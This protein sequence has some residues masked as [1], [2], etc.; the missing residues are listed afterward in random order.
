MLRLRFS[1]LAIWLASATSSCS[2][3]AVCGDGLLGGSEACDDGN[4][5]TGDGCSAECRLETGWVCTGSAP[6]VC[7]GLRGDGLV[8]GSEVCDDGNIRDGDG[9][10][11]R[12]E[13]EP[14]WQCEGSFCDGICG[15]GERRGTETCDDGNEQA[16]DG[17]SAGCRIED[18][19]DCR[20]SS[21]YPICGDGELRGEESCDDGERSDGDGCSAS[22]QIEDGWAC[23]PEAPSFCY[24][25]CGDG[26]LRGEEE[27]DDGNTMRG[28]GCRGTCRIEDGWICE[29]GEPTVCEEDCGD[30]QM[31]G[32]EACDDGDT[33]PDDA[34]SGACEPLEFAVNQTAADSQSWPS[35][36]MAPDGRF[37]IAWQ[38]FAQDGDGF[39]IYMRL[40]DAGGLP[41]SAELAVNS[42]T[43]EGQTYP[44]ASMADDGRLVVVWQSWEQ[45]GSADGVFGQRFAADGRKQGGEF[46]IPTAVAGGQAWPAVSM[47]AD[48]RFAVCW[49]GMQADGDGWGV[50]C[51]RFGADGAPAGGEIAVNAATAGDQWHATCALVDSG[52]LIVAW[53]GLA[54]DGFRDVYARV[55]RPDGSAGDEISVN[56]FTHDNQTYPDVAAWPDGRFVVVWSSWEQDCGQEG[57]FAR[58]FE[59]SGAPACDEFQV[60]THCDN[61]QW[62]PRVAVAADG[63]FAVVWQSWF[64]DAASG[65]GVY[66]Q[67][68][69]MDGEALGGEVRINVTVE[70]DQLYPDLAL[71]ADGRMVCA[72]NSLDQDGSEEGVFAR[73]FPRFERL[74]R[75]EE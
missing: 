43:E 51:Q 21:C 25:V 37:A 39:G 22:C 40:F 42:T 52:D 53:Y 3:G 28:D 61:A 23:Y 18:G 75:S 71:A 6:S 65:Y 7:D 34:C 26:K 74:S 17:C 35:L 1:I 41:A 29:P 9:C 4:T 67:R 55:L 38:S 57:I 59:A 10:S 69:G 15:D 27:C 56:Q 63:R 20:L 2:D 24:A 68:Y 58:R 33:E 14:Y 73:V 30:G 44:A 16:G 13:V 70:S 62:A 54:A 12:G 8:H 48:G 46:M 45:D 64:Q 11:A 66:A 47:A 32:S 19:W 36:A 50:V 49:S 5:A 60:N 72:W 31:V